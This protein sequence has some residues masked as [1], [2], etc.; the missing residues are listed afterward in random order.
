MA[1]KPPTSRP[2]SAIRQSPK[3]KQKALGPETK[4]IVSKASQVG[5]KINEDEAKTRR[6]LRSIYNAE[7][8]ANNKSI[9]ESLVQFYLRTKVVFSYFYHATELT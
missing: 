9:K 4:Q 6:L 2:S 8:S 5:N 1:A 3:S 7:Q